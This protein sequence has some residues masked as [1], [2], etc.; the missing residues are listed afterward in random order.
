MK[1]IGKIKGKLTYVHSKWLLQIEMSNIGQVPRLSLYSMVAKVKPEMLPA[2]YWR[3]TLLNHC[4]ASAISNKYRETK[5]WHKTHAHTN[6]YWNFDLLTLFCSPKYVTWIRIWK[7]Y[8]RQ[9]LESH[10]IILRAKKKTSDLLEKKKI[11]HYIIR[12]YW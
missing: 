11:D 3:M 2:I 5:F 7:S 10:Q 6:S 1:E 8:S 4:T 12:K 9:T